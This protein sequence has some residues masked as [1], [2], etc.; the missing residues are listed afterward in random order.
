MTTDAVVRA[1]IDGEVK[2]KAVKVLGEMG[3]SVSDAIHMLL[4]RV[5]AVDRHQ[6]VLA[7]EPGERGQREA[8]AVHA[9]R[10]R[11][12]QRTVELVER[13]TS[14]TSRQADKT[15][16]VTSAVSQLEVVI[17]DETGTV[18]PTQR[19]QRKGQ[20]V[21]GT[22]KICIEQSG[23]VKDVSTVSSIPGA[24]ESIIATLRSWTFKPQPIPVCT[25]WVMQFIIE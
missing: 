2:A 16:E 21:Q 10:R 17:H 11:Q 5:A 19:A 1:R 24:D 6:L 20:T 4:V 8:A 15:T 23:S 22:Y 13:I 12:V 14:T 7:V 3:L 25:M 18:L 9:H